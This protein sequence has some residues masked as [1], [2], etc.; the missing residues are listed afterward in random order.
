MMTICVRQ[1]VVVRRHDG[2]EE[3]AGVTAIDELVVAELDKVGELG[4]ARIDD[5]VD[6]GDQLLA[7]VVVVGDV[8]LGQPVLALSVEDQEILQLQPKTVRQVLP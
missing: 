7:L 6:V 4:I 5:A 3:Q 8:P 2:S 1:L